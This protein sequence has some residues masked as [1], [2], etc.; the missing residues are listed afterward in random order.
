MNR[1]NKK[2]LAIIIKIVFYLVLVVWLASLVLA[3]I[4]S[5]SPVLSETIE[6]FL[7]LNEDLSSDNALLHYSQRYLIISGI[8]LA[9]ILL[10]NEI[11]KRYIDK[12]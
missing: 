6:E 10:F 7:K 2:S 12:K 5:F 4:G 1:K 11:K 8:V 3:Y 9:V